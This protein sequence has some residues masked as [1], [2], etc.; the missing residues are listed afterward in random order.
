MSGRIVR[1]FSI[2][3]LDSRG[4]VHVPVSQVAVEQSSPIL[5][6]IVGVVQEPFWQARPAVIEIFI[7]AHSNIRKPDVPEAQTW[8]A[9]HTPFSVIPTIEH[10]A[11]A[12]VSGHRE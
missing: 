5:A 2:N 9:S 1:I 10:T 8:V 11:S 4:S 3:F 6:V 12:Q 7:H